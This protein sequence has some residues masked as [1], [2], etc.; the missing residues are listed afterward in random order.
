MKP[1]KVLKHI[2]E[3]LMQQSVAVSNPGLLHGKMGLA[4]FF[5]HYARYTGDSLFEDHAMVLLDNIQEQLRYRHDIDYASGLAG[6]G[7]GIEYLV[8][9]SFIEG[10][11]HEILEEVDKAIFNATISDDHTDAGL[12][13]GLT[14]AGRYLLFRIAGKDT[15]DDYVGTLDNKMLLIH[16]TDRLDRMQPVLKE[17]EAGDIYRFLYAMDQANILPVK[18]KRM[19]RTFSSRILTLDQENGMHP[20]QRNMETLL[21]YRYSALTF[22][23]QQKCRSMTGPDLYGGLAGIGLYIISKLDKQYK[24]WMELL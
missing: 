12:L 19:I 21:R 18:V 14:D 9:N 20:Y 5:L 2:A 10:N 8:Q 22:C 24:K 11:T 13:T 1:E 16:I 17:E 15:N 4:V 6:I 3:R 23:I 7:A